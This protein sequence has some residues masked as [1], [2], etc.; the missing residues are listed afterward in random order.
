MRIY[1]S[2]FGAGRFCTGLRGLRG[3][4]FGNPRHPVIAL[5]GAALLFFA[6]AAPGRAAEEGLADKVIEA[7]GGMERL[8]ATQAIRTTSSSINFG[9]MTS[10]AVGAP[11]IHLSNSED[12]TL[13]EPASERFRIHSRLEALVPFPGGFDFEEAYDGTHPTRAGPRDFRPGT[14]PALPGAYLGARLKRLWLD[15]PQWLIALADGLDAMGSTVSENGRKYATLRIRALGDVWYASIDPDTF[16]PRSVAFHEVDALRGG[17]SRIE[18]RYSDWREM[19]GIMMPFR[20]EQIV[21]RALTRRVIRTEISLEAEVAGD[22]YRLADISTLE[23]L[24]KSDR[25]NAPDGTN[26]FNSDV[27]WGRNMSHWFLGRYAMGRSSEIRQHIPVEFREIA[28]GIFQITGTT[29]HNLVVVGPDSLAVFEAPFYA[30]RSKEVLAALRQ[31]WPDK[32]VQ[33]LVLTHHHTDHIGGMGEYVKAGA[34]L[35]VAA[36]NGGFFREIFAASE[37]GHGDIITIG[38]RGELPDFG[39]PVELLWVPNSHAFD[40]IIAYFPD[41]KLLFAT[42]IYSPGRPKQP[43]NY[44]GELLQAIRYYDL[45]VSQFIGGHGAGPDSFARFLEFAE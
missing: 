35:V 17:K 22:E 28:E 18:V 15:H 10:F 36:A 32:P 27:R 2:D 34:Q 38:E 40:M 44:P 25:Y 9:N 19:D 29:H 23:P 6:G 16:L 20:I 3:S 1:G 26:M 4:F 42:D 8:K 39:R 14:D 30:A 43:P 13:W 12:V 41:Q 31:R 11:P 37:I 7:L 5:L 21:F 24:T 45:E 33:Y